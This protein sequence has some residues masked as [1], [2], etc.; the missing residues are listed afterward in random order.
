VFESLL[1]MNADATKSKLQWV[2]NPNVIA[3]GLKHVEPAIS[4]WKSRRKA[5]L[6]ER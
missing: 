6:A 1:E 2:F 3:S 4:F 5:I